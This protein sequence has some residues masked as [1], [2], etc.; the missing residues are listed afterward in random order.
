MIAFF[1]QLFIIFTVLGSGIGFG[2]STFMLVTPL[3]AV[4]I[5]PIISLSVCGALA[6][7]LTI[8]GLIYQFKTNTFEKKE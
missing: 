7:A 8:F 5:A 6:L 1:A 4:G 3:G 2:I